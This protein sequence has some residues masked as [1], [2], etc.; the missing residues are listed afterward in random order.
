VLALQFIG[1]EEEEGDMVVVDTGATTK[2]K[3]KKRVSTHGPKWK[4]LE[5]E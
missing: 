4:L 5:D 2:T 1:K 3:K